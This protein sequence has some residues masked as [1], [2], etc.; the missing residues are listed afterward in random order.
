MVWR[1]RTE[2]PCSDATPTLEAD[3]THSERPMKGFVINRGCRREGSPNSGVWLPLLLLSAMMVN[4]AG[5]PVYPLK[6]SA[7][8]RFL[9]DQSNTPCMIVGDSPQAL[10]V[11]ISEADAAEY[12]TNRNARGF[13]SL[14]IDL[15]CTTYTGGRTNGSTIDG[16]LPFTGTIPG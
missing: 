2:L 3:H 9:V 1:Q 11:N 12:F 6:Q 4:V 5:A 16:T 8:G 7:S 10:V 13:N 15:L 14:C